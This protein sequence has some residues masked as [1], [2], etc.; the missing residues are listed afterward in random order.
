MRFTLLLVLYAVVE[1]DFRVTECSNL[2]GH[3][4]TF[5]I[6]DG[7]ARIAHGGGHG[8]WRDLGSGLEAKRDYYVA[9]LIETPRV[10]ED[11]DCVPDSSR[12]GWCLDMLPRDYSAEVVRLIPAKDRA[13]AHRML[14]D[15]QRDGMSA[16][17]ITW[18]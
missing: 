17:A 1:L 6:D 2:G 4:Y 10:D 7:T 18:Y 8:V 16:E 14:A 9:E 15:V 13:D 12:A 5:R 3:H 11:H